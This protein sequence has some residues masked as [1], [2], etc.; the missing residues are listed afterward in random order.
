VVVQAA[1]RQH[2]MAVVVVLVET[3]LSHQEPLILVAVVAVSH[4]KA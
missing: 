4:L 2:Q 1:V 3:E